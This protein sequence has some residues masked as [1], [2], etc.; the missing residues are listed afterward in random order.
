MSTAH[1]RRV[2]WKKGRS[3]DF[4]TVLEGKDVTQE[5]LNTSPPPFSDVDISKQGFMIEDNTK[6]FCWVVLPKY[7]D[8]LFLFR[9][10]ATR[11]GCPANFMIGFIPLEGASVEVIVEVKGKGRSSKLII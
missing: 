6:K 7:V 9:A 8:Y 2:A 10:D 1:K 4:T 11:F 5:P 3:L